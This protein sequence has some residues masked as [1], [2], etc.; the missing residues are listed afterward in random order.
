MALPGRPLPGFQVPEAHHRLR[1]VPDGGQRAAVGR[2]GHLI[3]G[4]R[5]PE[6]L[7]VSLT[8]VMQADA[9]VL[10]SRSQGPAVRADGDGVERGGVPPARKQF[11][12]ARRIDRPDVGGRAAVSYKQSPAVT[13]QAMKG[14]GRLDSNFHG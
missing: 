6:L 11:L 14:V 7:G 13:T 8:Q 10:A 2:E 9:P 5:H 3:D 4:A 12:A 1:G